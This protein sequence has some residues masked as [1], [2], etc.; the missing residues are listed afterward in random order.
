MYIKKITLLAWTLNFALV[1][2]V[3]YVWGHYD[4]TQ[5]Q[6]EVD[7]QMQVRY[8]LLQAMNEGQ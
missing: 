8:A 7:M 4:G 3:G 2:M 1:G 6:K 5:V